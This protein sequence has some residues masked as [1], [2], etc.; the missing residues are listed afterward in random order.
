MPRALFGMC[1]VRFF[2]FCFLRT[3][4]NVFCFIVSHVSSSYT[5]LRVVGLIV[6]LVS[7]LRT[8]LYVSFMVVWEDFL[9]R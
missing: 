3:V 5:I 9:L 4:L 6:C 1:S 2:D 8:F 7:A